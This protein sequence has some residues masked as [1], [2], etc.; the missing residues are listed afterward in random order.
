MNRLKYCALALCLMLAGLD[1]MAAKVKRPDSYNYLRGYEAFENDDLEQALE[2]FNK[3]LQENPKNGYSHLW[4]SLIRMS[5]EEYG[6]ALSAADQAI[7]LIPGKDVE[8]VTYSYRVRS[9]V[10]LQLEDTTRALADLDKAIRINPK[11][12]D[13]YEERGQVYYEQQRYDDADADYRQMIALDPGATTGYMGLG[14]DA[15]DRKQWDEAIKQLDYVI[16]LES[17]YAQAYSFRA[18]SYLGQEK[19]DEATDD[20][21]TAMKLGWDTYALQ[22]AAELKEPAFS[23]LM[24][25]MKVQMAKNSNDASWPFFAGAFYEQGK[26]YDKAIPLYQQANQRDANINILN[27]IAACYYN[28]GSNGQALNFVNQALN[29]DSTD[30]DAIALKTEVL[31][32]LG[33]LDQTILLADKLV[34]ADPENASAY[35]NRGRLKRYAGDLEGAIEDLNMAIVLD[36]KRSSSYYLRAV[37]Y[38]MLDKAE[39]AAADYRKVIELEKKPD[40]YQCIQYALLALGQTDE[41][42]AANDTLMARDTT[43]IGNYYNAACLYSRMNQPDKALQYLKKCLDMGYRHFGHMRLDSDLDN[44]RDLDEYKALVKQY[45]PQEVVKATADEQAQG[46][47][48]FG[49]RDGEGQVTEVPFT[50]ED[51]VCKVKCQINGLPLFFV[52]DTGAS[53]VTISMVEATFMVKNGYL[54]DSDIVGSQ[55]YMDANGNVTVGTVINLKTVDFGGLTLTN[56]RASVVRNQK[57]PLLLGQSV[58]GRLGKIQIDNQRMVLSIKH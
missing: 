50:K 12:S 17:D 27:R 43:D 32:E 13:L 26:M 47:T 56:V 25:K 7:K 3:D 28:L 39:Q 6:K 40:D 52:F 46:E 37:V 49:M 15:N 10:Y 21:I 42:L 51:G 48:A 35:A 19:W 11:E 8:Y 58:L 54:T 44:I 20:L 45:A 4:I 22:Q 53:D 55:R 16:K 29:M 5:N 23:L 34:D 2:Y 57:A 9:Q 33:T 36:P 41:A 38:G 30:N 24:A 18:E 1:A 14:R 31:Y